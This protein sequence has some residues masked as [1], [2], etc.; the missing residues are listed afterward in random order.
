LKHST[1]NIKNF[2]KGIELG[3]LNYQNFIENAAKWHD[4]LLNLKN[5][6]VENNQTDLSEECDKTLSKL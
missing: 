6:L 5:L 3:L 2:I 1:D 4:N